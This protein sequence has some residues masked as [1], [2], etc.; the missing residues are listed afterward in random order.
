MSTTKDIKTQWSKSVVVGTFALLLGVISAFGPR[1]YAQTQAQANTQATSSK[2]S[3]DPAAVAKELQEVKAHMAQLESQLGELAAF[4]APSTNFAARSMR[5]APTNVTLTGLVSCAHCQGMQ[6]MHKGYT[7]YSWALYSVSLGDDI[8]L[9]AHD[10]TYKL[11]GDKNQLLKFMS[12]KA[13]IAGRLDNTDLQVQTIGH[14]E[15]GE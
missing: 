14:P 1:G 3:N 11:Q 7:Q 6:P 10:K 15:K 4:V 13:R 2:L 9:V 12:A 8:V 5:R